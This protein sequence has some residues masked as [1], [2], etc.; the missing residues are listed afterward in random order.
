MVRSWEALDALFRTKVARMAPL[1]DR[2]D[3]VWARVLD[4]FVYRL[5]IWRDGR[6][7]E[8][9]REPLASPV[10]ARS[11]LI[12]LVGRLVIEREVHDD[13]VIVR[14][15]QLN[16]PLHES[17]EPPG[18]GRATSPTRASRARRASTRSIRSATT[19][20]STS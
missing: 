16:G 11:L 19:A 17:H 8:P 14:R 4:R 13:G 20:R 6:V 9:L 18:S 12:D 3:E 5:V 10:R 15:A 1:I 7:I 2:E